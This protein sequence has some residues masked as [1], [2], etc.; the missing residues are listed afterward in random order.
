MSFI[1]DDIREKVREQL[2]RNN[3]GPWTYIVGILVTTLLVG[4]LG[5]IPV[6][7]KYYGYD[8]IYTWFTESEWNQPHFYGFYFF[9][10]LFIIGLIF[11]IIDGE[12]DSE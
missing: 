9:G 11:K 4:V 5:F 2:D 10:V 7:M 8:W 3:A 6:L 1:P 12:D